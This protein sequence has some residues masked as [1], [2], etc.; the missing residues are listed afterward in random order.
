MTLLFYSDQ[1]I[2]NETHVLLN[3]PLYSDLRQNMS[4][5]ILRSYSNFSTLDEH[6]KL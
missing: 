1:T 6:A 5:N 4:S 3:C 2:E